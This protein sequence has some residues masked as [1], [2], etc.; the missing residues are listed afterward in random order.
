MFAAALLSRPILSGTDRLDLEVPAIELPTT[1]GA[2]RNL[3]GVGIACFQ[4]VEIHPLVCASD[5]PELSPDFVL[6]PARTPQRDHRHIPL[7]VS[8]G[9]L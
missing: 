9:T 4:I 5:P 7:S 3:L 2:V 6:F 1:P 8:S